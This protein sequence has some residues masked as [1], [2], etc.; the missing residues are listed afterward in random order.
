MI[1]DS[2]VIVSD[3]QLRKRKS[4]LTKADDFKNAKKM[5]SFDVQEVD[6]VITDF[7][8]DD[9]YQSCSVFS[10]DGSILATAGADGSI[11]MWTVCILW[12]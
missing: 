11:R 4:G 1:S 7:H 6:S 3:G 9:A 8:K 12:Q 5:I 2:N 10:P